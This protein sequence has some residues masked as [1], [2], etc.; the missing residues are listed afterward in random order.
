MGESPV[1][2]R[3]ED[4]R[5]G[6]DYARSSALAFSDHDLRWDNSTFSPRSIEISA[7]LSP[8]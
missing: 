7:A 5:V 2:E 1:G 6:G 8:V 4:R 3:L